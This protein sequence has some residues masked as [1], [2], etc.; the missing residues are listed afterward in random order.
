MKAE[1]GGVAELYHRLAIDLGAEGMRAVIDKAKTVLVGNSLKR[2]DMTRHPVNM[3]RDDGRST[4]CDR[5]LDSCRIERQGHWVDIGEDRHQTAPSDGI[6]GSRR[7]ERRCNH[8]AGKLE[9]A[10]SDRERGR[11]VVDKRKVS[12]AQMSA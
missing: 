5:T 8:L 11:T 9:R 12:D 10:E 4:G 3:D 6:D 1:D 7:G 2:T